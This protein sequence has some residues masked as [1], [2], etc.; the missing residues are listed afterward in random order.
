MTVSKQDGGVQRS[1]R[2]RELR[3][4]WRWNLITLAATLFVLLWVR[5]LTDMPLGG[6][7]GVVV[8]AFFVWWLA[9]SIALRK[10]PWPLTLFAYMEVAPDLA[11][12]RG[13]ASQAGRVCR[14]FA[15]L[16]ALGG[17]YQL[18]MGIGWLVRS[19][20]G[21]GR[22]G[23]GVATAMISSSLVGAVYGFGVA[24]A[25]WTIGSLAQSMGWLIEAERKR[26]ASSDAGDASGP[27]G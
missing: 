10:L 4:W 2:R 7:W 8:F 23:F 13:K 6:T 14:V 21:F 17:C 25:L 11:A 19:G 20:G 26:A 27:Q 16:I 12:P 18:V 22:G 15:V 24:A 9:P 3:P 5:E 1:S